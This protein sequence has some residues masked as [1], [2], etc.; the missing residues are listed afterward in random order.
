ML[1][2]EVGQ[3]HVCCGPRVNGSEAEKDRC[4]HPLFRQKTHP[5]ARQQQDQVESGGGLAEGAAPGRS[6]SGDRQ[7]K[8]GLWEQLIQGR[9]RDAGECAYQKKKQVLSREDGSRVLR[10]AAAA[11][12][13][14]RAVG[15]GQ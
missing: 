12:R 2:N 5:S 10:W 7:W 4:S 9:D 3:T 13:G 8:G 6:G 15:R 14:A 11:C 1:K